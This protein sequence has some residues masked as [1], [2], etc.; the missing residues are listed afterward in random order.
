LIRVAHRITATEAAAE[1]IFGLLGESGFAAGDRL[2]SEQELMARLDVGRSTVREALQ[3]LAVLDLVEGRAGRGWVVKSPS[4]ADLNSHTLMSVL[5]QESADDI[6]ELRA[7]LEVEIAALA[8][9]RA[10][11]HDLVA[12]RH[13]LERTRHAMERQDDTFQYSL[14]FHESLASAA[15]NIAVLRIYRS[16]ASLMRAATGSTP[17]SAGDILHLRLQEHQAILDA[18]Q[19]R[20]PERA[21][22]AMRD[23][24]RDAHEWTVQR[25][26]PPTSARAPDGP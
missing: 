9:I 25:T 14:L 18:V 6:F 5:R 13:A 20:R 26:E 16:V 24:L 3:R 19:A 4:G 12:L 2:P 15:H 7:I 1:Q 21:R 11:S 22:E 17:M 8:A 23:H 10:T